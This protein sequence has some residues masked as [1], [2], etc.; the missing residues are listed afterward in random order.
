MYYVIP[1]VQVERDIGPVQCAVHNIGANIGQVSIFDT[2]TRVYSKVW[3][4]A[5]LSAFLFGREVSRHMV[6]RGE[7]TIILTGATAS[8]RGAVGHSAFSSAMASIDL[9]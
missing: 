9:T 7:G 6:R 5:A 1:I 2:T 3:E 4:M 8:L